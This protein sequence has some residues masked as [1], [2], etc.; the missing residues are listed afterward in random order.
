MVAPFLPRVEPSGSI[1]VDQIR[2]VDS[3]AGTKA[4]AF[5][6]RATKRVPDK[7][8]FARTRHRTRDRAVFHPS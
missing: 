3:A 6:G 1:S 2:G 5:P 7:R 4:P 8:Q